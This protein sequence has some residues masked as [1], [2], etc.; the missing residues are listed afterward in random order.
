MY[1]PARKWRKRISQNNGWFRCRDVI[2]DRSLAR[3]GFKFSEVYVKNIKNLLKQA[4]RSAGDDLHRFMPGSN[5]SLQLVR[6]LNRFE[7]DLVLDVGANVGQFASELR[8][9]GF[10]GELVSFEPLSAAHRVL[11]E[12]SRPDAKWTVHP[13]CAIG[14]HDSDVEINV[15]GNSISSSVLPMMESHSAAA[16]DSAYVGIEKVSMFKLD[17]VAS[18]YMKKSNRSF[19]KIDTQGFEWQV[20][21]GA[22]ETLPHVQGI[23][24]ELSLVPLYDGQRLWRDLIQRIE[25]EGFALWFIQQGFVDNRDGR[26][27]QVDAAFF[28]L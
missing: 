27:L 18:R 11:S 23:L 26:T 5:P 9:A 19:L 22:L 21:D 1:L 3:V 13:R 12:A 20:L 16:E 24:C 4:I 7:V 8:S 28:R 10:R 15:A 14:D 6:A 25:R 17:S 2:L